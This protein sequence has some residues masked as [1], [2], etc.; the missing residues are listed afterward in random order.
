MSLQ[1]AV[2]LITEPEAADRVSSAVDALDETIREIRSAIFSLQ[3]HGGPEA[4]PGL[5][6]QILRRRR[7]ADR[8]ARV[9]PVAAAG[10]A[11]WTTRCP[12][13][14]AEHL[15]AVLREALSNAARHAHA[16][17]PTWT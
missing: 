12:D 17:E 5:R 15:L 1:G 11:G 3:S 2:P 10:R 6:A 9:R 8:A 16:A 13:A 14:S 7:G 4:G